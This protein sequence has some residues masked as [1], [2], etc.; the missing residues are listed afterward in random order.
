MLVKLRLKE[1][2]NQNKKEPFD[3]QRA[4]KKPKLV[5]SNTLFILFFCVVT[6]VYGKEYYVNSVNGNDAN[7][8]LSAQSPWKT[9]PKA[10]GAEL[11]AGDTLYFARGSSF[12]GGIEI[13]A[14]GEPNQPIT[15]TACGMGEA[16]KFSN[17]ERS[18]LNGNAVRLSGDWLVVDGL[19]FHDCAAAPDKDETYTQIWDVGAVRIMLG[20]DHCTV[21]NCEFSNCPK[22]IQST[23]EYT[24]ITGNTL[25]SA[26]T[27]PLSS[28]G[29][30]PIAVHLGNG[31]QEVSYNIITDY[32]FI[33]G[34]FGGDGGAIE[35][36]DGRNPKT[37]IYIHHNYP[38]Q[39]WDFSKSVGMRILPK[40]KRT[41]F[42]SHITSAMITR[43]LSCSGLPRTT[44]TLKIIPS[45][46]GGRLKP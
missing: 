9:L 7:S 43:I 44:R 4:Q 17:P 6:G 5:L 45:S 42:A 36:D 39:T 19:Y 37:D 30:G 24:L 26:T 20:A 22:G 10:Q 34:E 1:D 35:L 16:P 15:L 23:G 3:A 29:W 25:H 11:H 2:L 38:V 41:T 40:P 46:D 28:P 33:G 32:Y 12:V 27:R 8:G 13:T 31:H 18:I 14:S 21:R